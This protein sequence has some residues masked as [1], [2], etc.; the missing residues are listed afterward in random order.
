MHWKKIFQKKLM[1]Q[2]ILR[3]FQAICASKGNCSFAVFLSPG[4]FLADM[5]TKRLQL[6][7]QHARNNALNDLQMHA[8]G[9]VTAEITA[10]I[11]ASK[12]LCG[13]RQNVSVCTVVL[14]FY[15]P[16][17]CKR[18]TGS[19]LKKCLCVCTQCCCHTVQ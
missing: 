7:L 18:N 11:R 15:L 5:L 16:T 12:S 2:V 14:S 8:V 6:I 19:G 1:W 13:E 4:A 10:H 3:L 17:W 9:E